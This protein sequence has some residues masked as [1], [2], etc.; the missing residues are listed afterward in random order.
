[1]ED[2]ADE[3]HRIGHRAFVGGDGPYWDVVSELQFRFLREQGLKP[4][5]IFVD[6]ACGSLRGGRRF[7]EFLRPGHYLGLDK[8]IELVIYG[9]ASELSIERFHEKRPRFV[10]SSTFEF[11]RFA[12]APTYGL[13]QSLFSHLTADD[14]RLCLGRLR[15]IAAPGCRF[16]A[17]HHHAEKP[18]ENPAASHSHGFFAYTAEEIEG[19]GRETGWEASYLGGWNHPRGQHMVAYR[20]PG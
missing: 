5:D 1:L 6:V 12:S 3:I 19:F 11:E 9:V 10:I 18:Q 8:Y 15:K 20:N 14:I 7:I 16:F 17:T 4:A 13:A 2:T